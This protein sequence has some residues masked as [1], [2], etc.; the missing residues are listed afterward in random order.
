M[1]EEKLTEMRV[2]LRY[3]RRLAAQYPG[4]TIENIIQNIE[5]RIKAIEKYEGREDGVH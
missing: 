4:R 3:A 5:S 1:D 2:D